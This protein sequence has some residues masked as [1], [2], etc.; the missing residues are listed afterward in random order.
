MKNV[1]R[2]AKVF[3]LVLMFGCCFQGF[4]EDSVVPENYYVQA[5]EIYIAP[6]GMYASIEGTLIQIHI[7]CAD[8]RGIF[9]PVE[10]IIAGDLEWCPFC[11]RWYDSEYGHS[12][13]RGSP[14]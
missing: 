6:N 12:N 4:A 10:E 13:C 7:L 1:F 11:G 8:E 5:R 2:Y 3:F 9:V 14:E